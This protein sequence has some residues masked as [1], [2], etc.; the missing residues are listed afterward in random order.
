MSAL[1]AGRY[2]LRRLVG[3]GGIAEVHR[4]YDH[5]T[6]REVALKL[7]LA[8]HLADRVVRRRFLREAEL[9]RELAHPNVVPV[10]DVGEHEGRPFFTMELLSGDL[11]QALDLE[12]KLPWA[13]ARQ[14][15]L[16]VAAAL[17]HAHGRGVIHQ[18]VKPQN[19]LFSD[20]GTAKLADFGL[21]RVQTLASVA[22]SSLFWGSPEY[23][24]PERFGPVRLDPRSD[25]YSLG[26]MIFEM[27]TGRLPF[28][29]VTIGK[30]L[31]A[32]ARPPLPP[33][34]L[35]P[36]IDAL[37]ASLL[38]PAAEDRPATA[39]EVRAALERPESA[40][41]PVLRWPCPRCRGERTNDV[42]LCPWCGIRD[43]DVAHDPRGRYAVEL[44]E[45]SD[46][47]WTMEALHRELIGLT[48]I[49]DLRLKF[50]TGNATLYSKNELATSLKLPTVL[51]D[52]M[53]EATALRLARALEARGFNVRAVRS[54]KRD[55]IRG[56]QMGM[57]VFG[58]LAAMS[59]I[60]FVAIGSVPFAALAL[61]GAAGAWASR[62]EERE[63]ASGLR[64]RDRPPPAPAAERTF[65]ASVEAARTV[66][67]PEIRALLYDLNVELFRLARRAE[68]LPDESGALAPRVRHAAPVLAARLH[69]TAQRLEA[70]DQALAGESA[71]DAARHLAALQRRLDTAAVHEA[72]AILTARTEVERALERRHAAED[73]RA[74]LC[75]TLCRQLGALRDLCRQATGLASLAEEETRG[76]EAALAELEAEL[77]GTRR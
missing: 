42:P 38:S 45:I 11:R 68:T 63:Q 48:G 14:I 70:L 4:A 25:L 41:A 6:G 13:R 28:P 34:G 10:L 74:R 44:L 64:L 57:A 66:E 59:T 33:L 27:V 29:G 77:A 46:D 1:F 69:E 61:A 30:L 56:S 19:V 58:S 8:Q 22:G 21:A 53:D 32:T 35:G 2:E 16:D 52:Q 39:A 73:E 18:D 76:I 47:S 43:L 36:A 20:D 9:A 75:A 71:A 3:T 55:P 24:A 31:A 51:F 67:A 15:A 72:A 65:T 62:P 40:L 26:V 17:E 60:A 37:V 54:R 23:M 12:G 7:Q 49:P 5:E 50:I